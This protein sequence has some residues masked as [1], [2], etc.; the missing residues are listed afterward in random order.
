MLALQDVTSSG[1]Q[2]LQKGMNYRVSHPSIKEI[3]IG[4]INEDQDDYSNWEIAEPEVLEIRP[5]RFARTP[6]NGSIHGFRD[7]IDRQRQ[8]LEQQLEEL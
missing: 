7:R 3:K 6:E 5:L 4:R 1:R 2:V 8:E